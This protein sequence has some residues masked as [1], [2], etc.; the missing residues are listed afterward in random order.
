MRKQRF[1]VLKKIWQNELNENL[2]ISSASFYVF[3][4]SAF[5]PEI[6]RLSLNASHKRSEFND[7][8]EYFP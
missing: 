4:F 6:M 2:T 8:M 7:L 1:W 5:F 3:W